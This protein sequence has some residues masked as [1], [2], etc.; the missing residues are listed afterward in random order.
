VPADPHG[1][2]RLPITSSLNLLAHV[3]SPAQ[4]DLLLS[5]SV[6]TWL[7]SLEI[8]PTSSLPI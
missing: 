3:D 4:K 7:A 6:Q 2:P 8:L 5:R 1:K